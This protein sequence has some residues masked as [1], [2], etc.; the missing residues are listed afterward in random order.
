LLRLQRREFFRLSTPIATPVM[1]N[2]VVRRPDGST[3]SIDIPLFDI[4][5]GG[6]GLMVSPEMAGYLNKGDM[7]S[8]CRIRLDA[9]LVST[10]KRELIENFY[11]RSSIGR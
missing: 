8:E 2:A 5:G 9:S 3:L 4:S 10:I 7:L 1:M 6:V 11:R